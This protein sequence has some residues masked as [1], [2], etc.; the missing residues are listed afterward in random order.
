MKLG[1]EQSVMNPMTHG[2]D[3]KAM[4]LSSDDLMKLL[5]QGA[6]FQASQPAPVRHECSVDCTAK[7][8]GQDRMQQTTCKIL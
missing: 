4:K 1:L 8:W 7:L 6:Y 5:K 2:S 3:G